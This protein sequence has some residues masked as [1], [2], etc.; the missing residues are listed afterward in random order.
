VQ[1]QNAEDNNSD[2]EDAID[3]TQMSGITTAGLRFDW[4]CR[5]VN[6]GLQIPGVR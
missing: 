3:F 5:N 6:L 4:L 1:S 2:D